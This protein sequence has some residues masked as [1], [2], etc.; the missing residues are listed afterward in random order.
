[1]EEKIVLLHLLHPRSL[2]WVFRRPIAITYWKQIKSEK[3]EKY[4][5]SLPKDRYAGTNGKCGLILQLSMIL[6]H[7]A[8]SYAVDCQIISF[9]STYHDASLFLCLTLLN[10][11]V[12]YLWTDTL[13]GTS[14]RYGTR[15]IS[16]RHRVFCRYTVQALRI[17][18][19]TVQ[20]LVTGTVQVM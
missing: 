11:G 14:T 7:L 2:Q 5:K 15:Y 13:R 6:A 1:M 18:T 4:L 16:K 3:R 12:P 20:V 9:V 10:K 19:G 17:S 8:C